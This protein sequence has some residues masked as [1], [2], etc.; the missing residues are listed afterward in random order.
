MRPR[1]FYQ[2][3]KRHNWGWAASLDRA[4]VAQGSSREHELQRLAAESPVLGD[5][6]ARAQAEHWATVRDRA[7]R[8][9]K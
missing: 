3:C 7:R 2:A 1:D 4:V 8:E 6:Y 9:G 5:I